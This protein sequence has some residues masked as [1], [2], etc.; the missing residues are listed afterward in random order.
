MTNKPTMV[1]SCVSPVQSFVTVT[2]PNG[3]ERWSQ[4]STKTITWTTNNIS[5]SSLIVISFVNYF[6]NAEH[7]F[8]QAT[9]NGKKQISFMVP[10]N[11]PAN[12]YKVKVGTVYN[13]YYY[14]D[15]SDNYFTIT[16][17]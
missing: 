8:L 2:S 3:G 11:L 5:D 10:P 16:I 1:Q 4:K 6:T 12:K 13:G 14:Y 15:L 17:P 9:T 7:S